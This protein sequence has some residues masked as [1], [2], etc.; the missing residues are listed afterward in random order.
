[1]LSQLPKLYFSGTPKAGTSSI[2]RVI[3]NKLSP[4]ETLFLEPTHKIEHY[5]TES[6]LKLNI[7]DIPFDL[8]PQTDV[9]DG[10]L[11]FVHNSQDPQPLEAVL[12]LVAKSSKQC[13]VLLHK[14]DGVPEEVMLDLI[15]ESQ[16][17]LSE[18]GIEAQVI[19]TSIYDSSIFEGLSLVLQKHL[20]TPALENVLNITCSLTFIEKLYLLDASSKLYISMDSASL[21]AYEVLSDSIDMMVDCLAL[22]TSTDIKKSKITLSHVHIVCIRVHKEL[23]LLGLTRDMHAITWHNLECI[24]DQ[25]REIL[26]IKK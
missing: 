7:Y 26:K 25:V 3:F 19:A 11:I 9:S 6:V 10:H 13:T 4:N 22:Y 18:D 1:M 5:I 23:V 15:R 20:N 2:H 21:S 24:A 16:Q 8:L 17:R 12:P 14:R